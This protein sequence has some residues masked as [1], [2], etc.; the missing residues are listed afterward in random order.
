LQSEIALL[1]ILLLLVVVVVVVVV[2]ENHKVPKEKPAMGFGV[3][4]YSKTK[5]A[6]YSRRETRCN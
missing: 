1:L 6:G 3:I 5:S 4:I 2:V